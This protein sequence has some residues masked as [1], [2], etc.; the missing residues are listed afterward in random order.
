MRKATQS[1]TRAG[2][3]L[4]HVHTQAALEDLRMIQQLHNIVALSTLITKW[5]DYM[6]IGNKCTGGSR[7]LKEFMLTR[8]WC[9]TCWWPPPIITMM[10]HPAAL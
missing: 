4:Q 5:T 6:V 1:A 9:V 7:V 10:V 3:L 2:V 8:L